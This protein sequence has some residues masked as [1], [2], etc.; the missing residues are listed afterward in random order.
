MR[1]CGSSKS[2]IVKKLTAIGAQ[3]LKLYE[4]WVKLLNV[5]IGELVLSMLSVSVTHKW[6]KQLFNGCYNNVENVTVIML[7]LSISIYFTKTKT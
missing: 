6:S 3:N 5:V 4:R 7:V 1:I 2:L